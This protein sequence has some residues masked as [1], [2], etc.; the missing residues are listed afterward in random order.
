MTDKPPDRNK[1]IADVE[2]AAAAAPCGEEA[3]EL[4][5][6][7]QEDLEVQQ[8]IAV[9]YMQHASRAGELGDAVARSALRELSA[10]SGQLARRL[11]QLITRS[12]EQP[13]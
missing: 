11:Q 7:L 5:A 4:R 1:D 10:A 2:Q 6:M 3:D 9:L 13:S 8:M 12:Q